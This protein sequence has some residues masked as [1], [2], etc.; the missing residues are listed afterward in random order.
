MRNCLFSVV[1]ANQTLMFSALSSLLRHNHRPR[2]K[3]FFLFFFFS[4]K[5]HPSV[6]AGLAPH[7]LICFLSTNYPRLSVK[8]GVP[9]CKANARLLRLISVPQT[10]RVQYIHST[11]TIRHW[12]AYSL[13]WR[14][15]TWSDLTGS[16]QAS[17]P[18][19]PTQLMTAPQRKSLSALRQGVAAKLI[20]V[21]ISFLNFKELPLLVQTR[22]PHL[23][24]ML[25]S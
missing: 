23:T 11:Y 17:Q 21:I 3:H 13:Q 18:R 9:P 12:R 14:G 10:P 7:P 4:L 15:I 22:L 25:E 24:H 8:P 1:K 5:M 20:T 2:R 19:K 6:S 16:V